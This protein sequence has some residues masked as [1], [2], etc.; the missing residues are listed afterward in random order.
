MM[1]VAVVMNRVGVRL[2]ASHP[3]ARSAVRYVRCAVRGMRRHGF[4]GRGYVLRVPAGSSLSGFVVRG[5][6]YRFDCEVL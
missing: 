6:I 1:Y 2:V 5:L 3:S 4:G